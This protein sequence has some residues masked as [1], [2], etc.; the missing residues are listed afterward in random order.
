MTECSFKE[1]HLTHN[2]SREAA[3]KKC[4]IQHENVRTEHDHLCLI[5]SEEIAFHPFEILQFIRCIFHIL[6]AQTAGEPDKSPLTH[7]VAEKLK[8]IT[9]TK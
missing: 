4:S 6:L 3:S 1:M 5:C 9:V 7:T 2:F 8:F